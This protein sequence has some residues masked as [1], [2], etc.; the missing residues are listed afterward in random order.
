MKS[1]P[2]LT[3]PAAFVFLL[4]AGGAHGKGGTVVVSPGAAQGWNFEGDGAPSGTFEFAAGPAGKPDGGGSLQLATTAEQRSVL[5]TT[6]CAGLRLKDLKKLSCRVLGTAPV[7]QLE[8]DLDLKDATPLSEAVLIYDPATNGTATPGAW[9]TWNAGSGKWYLT[10][11]GF[12]AN[13]SVGQPFPQ[14]TPA[15]LKEILKKYPNAGVRAG[16]GRLLLKSGSENGAAS[17]ALDTL[18]AGSTTWNFEPDTDGDTV[19]DINDRYPNS[20]L[21]ATVNVGAG[22]TGIANRVDKK[23]ATIQDLVNKVALTAPTGPKYLKGITGIAKDLQKSGLVTKAEGETL[24]THAGQFVA[25]INYLSVTKNG[26]GSSIEL[27]YGSSISMGAGSLVVIGAGT[28]A[29]NTGAVTVNSGTLDLGASSSW[30]STV[31][32][33]PNNGAAVANSGTL[34]LTPSTLQSR[35]LSASNGLVI[36][37]P[38]SGVQL[39][40][41]G[42]ASGNIIPGNNNN[43]NVNVSIDAGMGDIVNAGGT[44]T[45]DPYPGISL[46]GGFTPVTLTAGAGNFFNVGTLDLNYNNS[47]LLVAQNGTPPLNGPLILNDFPDPGAGGLIVNHANTPVLQGQNA[48]SGVLIVDGS[49]LQLIATQGGGVASSVTG[50]MTVEQ[51]TVSIAGSTGAHTNHF[52][53]VVNAGATFEVRGPGSLTLTGVTNNGTMRV[54]GGAT[55]DASGAASFVNNGILDLTSGTA[56]LPPNFTNGPNGIVLTRESV[57]VKSMAFTGSAVTLTIDSYTG[58]TYQLQHSTSLSEGFTNVGASQTGATG[59]ALTFTAQ[60]DSAAPRGFYRIAVD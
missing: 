22:D 41:T 58:H 50:G 12:A 5:S 52:S 54:K 26:G 29:L 35:H 60:E 53:L 20:D 57:S 48:S 32:G 56:T 11:M 9:Q 6:A 10:G 1:L 49:N 16:T 55:L 4:A 19:P 45:L 31:G 51:G 43:N 28:P 47:G 24:K 25:Y 3:M 2:L 17:V 27:S 15:T 39:I 40:G 38:G 37:G 36:Q 46:S 23:G 44:L 33:R 34:Q 21:H 14:A 7:L 30:A 8:V 59:T 18:T 42:N 13:L